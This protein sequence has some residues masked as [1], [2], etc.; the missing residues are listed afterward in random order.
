MQ[1]AA[2]G[3]VTISIQQ[4]QGTST[5]VDIDNGGVTTKTITTKDTSDANDWT[6]FQ[7]ERTFGTGVTDTFFRLNVAAGPSTAKI[8]DT[9]LTVRRLGA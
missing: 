2:A 6:G 8:R 3:A 1:R 9:H 4:D 7:I 5:W